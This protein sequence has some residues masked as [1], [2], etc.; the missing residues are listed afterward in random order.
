MITRY[1]KL[2]PLFFFIFLLNGCARPAYQRP[3]ETPKVQPRPPAEEVA[4]VP[5]SRSVDH[6]VL[7]VIDP[8]HGGKDFGCESFIK[9]K[10]LE[11]QMALHTALMVSKYL[12]KMG[13][14]TMM[15]RKDD[16]FIPLKA[17]AEFANTHHS[18]LFVSVHYNSAESRQAQ[19]VEVF[20]YKSDE[21]PKRSASSKLLAGVVLD[22]IL[23]NTQAKSR[24]VK[25]GNFAV[26]R[27]TKMPAILIEAGFLTNDEEA[28]RLKDPV[29]QQR[30][31]YS[32]A[33]GINR[34][35]TRDEG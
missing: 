9:P 35:L 24:G 13:Y 1:A 33:E 10:D 11:K 23:K 18:A 28:L 8:G 3:V 34:H 32:I 6:S 29:Y 16:V 14:K 19:G 27:E 4:I 20:Y 26:I 31:A 15:T 5:P 2:L 25:H 22:Q 21:S 7:I 30:L 12:K 17:R